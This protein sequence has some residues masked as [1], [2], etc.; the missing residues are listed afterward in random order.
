[1]LSLIQVSIGMLVMLFVSG[2]TISSA[3]MPGRIEL[4]WSEVTGGGRSIR[5]HSHLHLVNL[6]RRLPRPKIFQHST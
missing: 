4:G 5:R 6:S 1:M 3:R 2:W